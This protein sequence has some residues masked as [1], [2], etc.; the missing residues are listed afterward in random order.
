MFIMLPI[1]ILHWRALMWRRA[2]ER[3]RADADK[4]YIRAR[5]ADGPAQ[6][7]EFRLPSVPWP[8]LGNSTSVAAK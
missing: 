4:L 5:A 1:N 8:F 7:G 2:L 3:E 6:I